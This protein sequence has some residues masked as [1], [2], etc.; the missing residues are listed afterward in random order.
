MAAKRVIVTAGTG[1]AG[2]WPHDGVIHTAAI[3]Q[4]HLRPNSE[5]WRVNMLS[6]HTVPETCGSHLPS[7]ERVRRFLR[8]VKDFCSE[9]SGQSA[10]LANGRAEQLLGW[11]PAF[12][13]R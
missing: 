2:H 3:S 8:N 7:R 10:W 5:V 13:L 12:F 1:K 9:L 4:P 6:T 11:K